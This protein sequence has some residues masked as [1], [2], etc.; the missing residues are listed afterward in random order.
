LSP[1]KAA[2]TLARIRRLA[3]IAATL[4]AASA[5]AAPALAGGSSVGSLEL[6][7]GRSQATGKRF[8][9]AGIHWQ[10][11]GSVVFRT[12]S[13]SGLWSAWRPA[14]PEEDDGPD[15]RSPEW[16][17]RAGWRIGNP[18]WVG[19]S[20]RIET[21]TSGRVTRVRV[22]LVRSPERRLRLRTPSATV[23]PA[24]VP[25]AAWGANESIRRGAPRYAD[26]ARFT[27]VHHT[28]GTNGYT[29]AQAPA[30]VKGIQLFHVQ[31]NGWNDIGYNYLVDRFGTIYEGRYGGVDR[32]VIG[33]HAMGFN[34]GAVGIA[35]LGTYGSTQPSKAAQDAIAQLIAWR[36]DL[37][38][39]DPTLT[40]TAVS[41]GSDRYRNG[42]PV[43]L[44]NVSGHR[45][46]GLTSCPGNALYSKLNSLAV[47]AGTIGLPKLYEPR[48]DDVE[49]VVRFRARLSATLPW[50]V[51]VRS[52]AGVEVAR[53]QG[54]GRTV[55]WSWDSTPAA[56]GRYTWSIAA[57]TA[58]PASGPLRVR[59]P[60]A[61][62]TVDAIATPAGVTPNGD[63]QN[64]AAT[65]EYRL[66]QSA[67]LTVQV[68][69]SA[70]AVVAT[71][72][73]RVWTGAGLR[74]L[75]IDANA[76]P[77]G[78]YTVVLTAANTLGAF[79]SKSVPLTVSRSLGLVTAAPPAFS[80]NGDG[81]NDTL[82]LRFS[83]AAPATVRIRV[84]R[85]GRWVATPFPA[86]PYAAGA[87]ALSWNG[88]RGGATV[89]D[90]AYA[91]VV[92]S[93]D[94]NGTVG[95]ELAFASDVTAPSVEILDTRK[96]RVRVSEPSTLFLR[97]NGRWTKRDVRK[98]GVVN[99]VTGAFAARVQAVAQDAAGNRS[100]TVTKV[101]TQG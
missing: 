45:D 90:G 57:G 97:I 51:A 78:R 81:R 16:E 1:E 69:N 11:E 79:V 18:W 55:D 36:L 29:R 52:A 75:T 15:A 54:T 50:T 85:E 7:P 58:R 5:V 82:E 19:P 22:H 94:V 80:P 12:R 62:L 31:S 73:D 99:V 42:V 24:I 9:L 28:A 39:V 59:G 86:A 64:D 2:A 27:I 66:S 44:R 88:K 95:A 38:H 13:L 56:W 34:T 6:E 63:G 40:T 3:V 43:L 30:I 10:G 8:T 14:A 35:L 98:A 32:N 41:S 37:A 91:V 72:V 89:R 47:A 84:L 4:A 53:G 87:H 74:T 100:P 20:D 77:D 25:R 67:S 23:T 48:V 76:L 61:T 65:L 33:A 101:R 93:T 26:A 92:D 21:R 71:P 68:V 83:L 49:G 17:R 46:T 96:L 60:G 70:L